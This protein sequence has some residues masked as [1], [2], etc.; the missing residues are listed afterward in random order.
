MGNTVGQ[1]M[2]HFL[3]DA[4]YGPEEE[5]KEVIKFLDKMLEKYPD[6]NGESTFEY[7]HAT[8]TWMEKLI[9][10]RNQVEH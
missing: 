1:S 9:E 6:W 4:T 2:C 10:F 7:I 5:V 8:K 3:H